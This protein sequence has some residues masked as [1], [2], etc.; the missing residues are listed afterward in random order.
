[1]L[2]FLTAGESH[3]PELVAMVEGVPAGFDID[4]GKIN[5]DLARRQAEQV[6]LR[7][8]PIRFE[9]LGGVDEFSVALRA[10]TVVAHVNLPRLI[11]R[12]VEDEHANGVFAGPQPPCGNDN[13]ESRAAQCL[14]LECFND[15]GALGSEARLHLRVADRHEEVDVAVVKHRGV[16]QILPAGELMLEARIEAAAALRLATRPSARASAL[17]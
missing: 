1:M 16:D 11:R 3:G 2:R 4:V 13:V 8:R 6:P 10:R 5:A 15:V 14:G 17:G 12:R 9:I 7:V